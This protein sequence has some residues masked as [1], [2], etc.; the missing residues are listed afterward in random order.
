MRSVVDYLALIPPLNA[1]K[2]LFNSVVSATVAP[3]ADSQEFFSALAQAFDLDVAIG[4]Q[5]DVVGQWV[6][7]SRNVTIPVAQPWF[8]WSN[9]L[10]GWGAGYWKGP[11]ILGDYISK[12][13][14]DTYRRL[15]YAKIIANYTDG[16]TDVAQAALSRYFVNPTTYVFVE[17]VAT[18]VGVIEPFS[19]GISHNGW[20]Q[21][22]W[23]AL[24]TFLGVTQATQNSVEMH[25]QIGVSGHLPTIVDL[26]ILAQNL[27][28]VTPA[29]VYLDI[30]VV[31][32]DNTPLFGW[33]MSSAVVS[34]WGAGSWGASPD[35]VA[36]LI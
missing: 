9:P 33:G 27:I 31:T 17:D 35:F 20:G 8:A 18:A 21:S 1:R 36:H 6:G 14:D 25:W 11:S 13:D 12:L 24:G 16:Q 10:R 5:L 2:P 22:Y 32:V 23:R 7:Q 15:L 19:W 4:V 34:G 28:P 3:Y 29:G 26:E 30:K